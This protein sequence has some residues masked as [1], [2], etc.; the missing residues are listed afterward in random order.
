METPKKRVTKQVYDVSKNSYK[1]FNSVPTIR[2]PHKYYVGVFGYEEIGNDYYMETAFHNCYMINYTIEGEA[3]LIYN[4]ATYHLKKGDL[5]LL[6]KYPRF[7]LTPENK[8][9]YDWKIF[10]WHIYGDD[11]KETFNEIRQNDIV[12]LHD[13]PLEKIKPAF[14][15]LTEEFREYREGQE[16]RVSVQLYSLFLD[17]RDFAVNESGTALKPLAHILD[18]IAANYRQPIT[19]DDIAKYTFVSKSHINSLFIKHLGVTPMQ[20]VMSLRIKR[21]QELLCSTNITIKRIAVDCGF[22]DDRSLI[23]AFKT[24]CDMTPQ[25]LR[26]SMGKPIIAPPHAQQTLIRAPLSKQPPLSRGLI[27][28][29]SQPTIYCCITSIF[30]CV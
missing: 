16:N 5:V 27:G 7:I 26:S 17:I 4:N 21:A 13:Y 25:Q 6:H 22:K 12:I 20:Y 1:I 3:K 18:Y 24:H 15:M 9:N 19:L 8:K 28:F 14:E 30:D 23:Y 10:F 29:F 11:I 2:Q